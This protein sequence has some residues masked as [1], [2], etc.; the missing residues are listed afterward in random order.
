MDMNTSNENLNTPQGARPLGFGY[1]DSVS[2]RVEMCT[3]D[4]LNSAVDSPR[5]AAVCADLRQLKATRDSGGMTHADYEVRKSRLKK[6]L[7]V[8]MPHAAFP[9][10]HRKNSEAV[11]SG[12]AMYDADHIGSP[13]DYW[14]HKVLAACDGQ[15]ARLGIVLA[16]ITPSYEGLRLIFRIPH[17]MTPAAAQQ[18][19]AT[20]LGDD[21]YDASVKDYARCSFVV[22]RG[23]FFFFPGEETV[24]G[25]DAAGH[26]AGAEDALKV[27]E[28]LPPVEP[29]P[30]PAAGAE[31]AAEAAALSFSGI[32]YSQIIDVWWKYNGGVPIE[33]ERNTKL[34]QLAMHLRH[35]CDNREQLLLSV[36]PRLGLSESE[37]K[38]VVRSACS[39]PPCSMP[40]RLKRVVAEAK[41]DYAATTC[42]AA[43]DQRAPA[44]C[45]RRS[46]AR[47]WRRLPTL[48]PGLKEATETVEPRLRM[49]AVLAQLVMIYT[50]LTRIRFD[51]F[52]G[53]ETRLSGLVFI[54]GP[55]ASGKAFIRELDAMWME[56]VRAADAKGRHMEAEYRREKELRKNERK[57]MERPHPVIRVVP[58]QI[59]NAMLITRLMDAV[60]ENADGM[61]RTGLHLYSCETELATA[62]RSQ[63]GGT[64]IEKND[65]YCKAFHNEP[66]GVDYA[67]D[68]VI[69]GEVEVNYNL[70]I[71][72]TE[73][74]FNTFVPQGT[75]L[76]GLPTRLMYFPMVAEP[77]RMMEC[78]KEMNEEKRGLVRS[79]AWRL[80]RLG[81]HVDATTLTKSMYKWCEAQADRAKNE[82]D[83]EL[84]DLRKRTALIGTRAGVAYAIMEHLDDF[85]RTGVLTVSSSAI[86]FA[87]V[88]ADFCLD[89]QYMKF[90]V[91]MRERKEAVGEKWRT[92]ERKVYTADVYDKLPE[93]F[94]RDDVQRLRPDKTVDAN[95]KLVA[96]WMER[97]YVKKGRKKGVYVKMM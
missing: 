53:S 91:M 59:S 1:A 80:D 14:Q 22:P 84:D 58:I 66:W 34:Y 13:H 5:V 55:A 31:W 7:P 10:G 69:N 75:V 88:V 54:I 44:A 79:V 41:R 40:R 71:S 68:Q 29:P 78:R 89:M 48:P 65:I 4:R 73:D 56:P 87:R 28:P 2:G 67:S 6:Q 12:L 42:A 27:N 92:A 16:H 82:L 52:D 33:G 15:P 24:W 35:I 8:I 97:G 76:S 63:R 37:L 32:P 86:K 3:W 19:M 36:L 39:A 81:G 23:Y 61:S 94:T 64:W 74:A 57:Q 25:P 72:G 47:W 11:P 38:A 85:E 20:R 90:S 51:H 26:D 17:G 77:F 60:E 18:W 62:I 95:R 45:S 49:G 50:L 70:V 21:T 46:W 30:L 43:D 93:S 83:Y 9:S 96:Y